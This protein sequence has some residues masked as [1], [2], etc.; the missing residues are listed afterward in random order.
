MVRYKAQTQ[1]SQRLRRQKAKDKQQRAE[2][3]R[4]R[5]YTELHRL[6]RETEEAVKVADSLK[7][8]NER[9]SHKLSTVVALHESET[10][11][12]EQARLLAEVRLQEAEALKAVNETLLAKIRSLEDQQ[13]SNADTIS[14]TE[15]VNKELMSRVDVLEKQL[16]VTVEQLPQRQ[17]EIIAREEDRLKRWE[18]RLKDADA[19][20][21][22]SEADLENRRNKARDEIKVEAQEAQA[23]GLTEVELVRK[24]L[25]AAVAEFESDRIKLRESISKVEAE[26]DAKFRAFS[27]DKLAFESMVKKFKEEKLKFE[28]ERSM[29]EP[30]MRELQATQDSVEAKQGVVEDAK[31]NLDIL[32]SRV[33]REFLQLEEKEKDLEMR[34]QHAVNKTHS[35]ALKGREHDRQGVQLNEQLTNLQTARLQVHEQQLAVQKQVADVKR[36][37]ISLRVLESRVSL[38]RN[39]LMGGTLAKEGQATDIVVTATTS[40]S[41]SIS[42]SKVKA[43]E[44][45]ERAILRCSSSLEELS[46]RSRSALGEIE[47]GPGNAMTNVVGIGVSTPAPKVTLTKSEAR[48]PSPMRPPA[49]PTRA[50][51]GMSARQLLQYQGP[52]VFG[53]KAQF[54]VERMKQAALAS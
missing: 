5:H 43:I 30:N 9:L 35:L 1:S 7:I 15:R 6:K 2:A 38:G 53:A 24:K 51:G 33:K 20:L 32:E 39:Q 31:S 12:S 4:A 11:S 18:D 28:I 10:S 13:A 49:P 46:L 27:A 54:A 42:P 16:N 40:T 3:R 21:K 48:E 50:S 52:I 47:L 26:Q 14:N 36:A 41:T 8:E 45:L 44:A 29:F 17:N 37:L 23:R 22:M 34:E 19:T 25:N